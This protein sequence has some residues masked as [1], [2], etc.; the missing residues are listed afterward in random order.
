MRR[1]IFRRDVCDV[2]PFRAIRFCVVVL[3]A[4]AAFLPLAAKSQEADSLREAAADSATGAATI[5]GF[6][7]YRAQYCGLCHAYDRADTGGIFGPSHNGMAIT[8]AERIRDSA[9]TGGASTAAEYIRESIIDPDLYIV[10]GFETTVHRMPAYRHLDTEEID[11]MV[12]FLL[13]A[14]CREDECAGKKPPD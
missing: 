9:Y 4:S 11:A 2:A 12:Q 8:A 7:T 5:S 10:P 1:N 13:E 6:D 3:L 14:D